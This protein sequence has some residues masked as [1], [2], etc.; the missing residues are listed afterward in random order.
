MASFI[1]DSFGELNTHA[2]ELLNEMWN[3][4][5]ER[6]STTPSTKSLYNSR[7]RYIDSLREQMD[8]L[9]VD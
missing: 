6:P 1:D 8:I 2:I 7:M 5:Q 4:E 3:L 9:Q